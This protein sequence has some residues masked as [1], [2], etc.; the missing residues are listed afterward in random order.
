MSLI[1]TDVL[2]PFV[3]EL[4]REIAKAVAEELRGGAGP[5]PATDEP[6]FLSTA[7]LG[8]RFGTS[9]EFWRARAAG[10]QIPARKVGRRYVIAL[11]DAEAYLARSA[12]ATPPSTRPPSA[13][14]LLARRP[15]GGR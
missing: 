5:A 11:A 12:P 14:E 2:R 9:S 15:R 6:G 1:D 7:A 8:E 13:D 3:R 10:G 4:A